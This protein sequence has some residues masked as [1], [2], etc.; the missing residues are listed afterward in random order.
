MTHL[1]SLH[2]AIDAASGDWL[3]LVPAGTFQSSDGRGPFTVTDPEA[4]IARSMAGGKLVL[5]ENHSTDLAAPQGNPAPARGWIVELQARQDGIWGRAEYTQAGKELVE[6]KAYRAISPVLASHPKTGEVGRILRASLV[7]DPSLN[8]KTLHHQ[9][10]SMDFAAKLRAALGLA[11]DIDDAATLAA[12]TTLHATAAGAAAHLS[13]IAE[14]AGAAKDAKPA[15]IT[16]A[17]KTLHAAKAGAKDER[18][19]VTTIHALQGELDTLKA[20]GATERATRYVDDAIKAGKPIKA[21]R[22]HYISRHAKDAASVEK[23]VG[24]LVSINSG[25]IVPGDRDAGGS[26]AASGLSVEQVM[27]K[28]TLHQKKMKADGVDIEFGAAVRFVTAS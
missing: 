17:V 6:G 5:D 15:E 28:A 8:L 25:G 11:A 1:L 21:L 7:N 13:A 22:E 27:E 23:E 24:A 14:A 16:E 12:V 18:D 2:H 4:L 3:H 20:T 10:R 19:L 9:E 26:G